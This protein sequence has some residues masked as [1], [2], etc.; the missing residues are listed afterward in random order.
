[1]KEAAKMKPFIALGFTAVLL[2]GCTDTIT[3]RDASGA[4]N[5]CHYT[6]MYRALH[7]CVQTS[8]ED[9]MTMANEPRWWTYNR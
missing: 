8:E 2:G 6:L 9:G 7:Q 4:E 1:M 5:V 3:M